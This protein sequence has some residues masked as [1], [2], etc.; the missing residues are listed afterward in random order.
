MTRLSSRQLIDS[1]EIVILYLSYRN[2]FNYG[3]QKYIIWRNMIKFITGITDTKIIRKIFYHL[4]N[5]NQFYKH[6]KIKSIYYIF[7]PSNKKIKVNDK[8]IFE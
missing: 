3:Y 8:V 5:K 6:K 7:N 1:V 2:S 4:L